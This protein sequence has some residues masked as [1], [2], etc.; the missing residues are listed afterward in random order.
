MFHRLFGLQ[1]KPQRKRTQVCRRRLMVE[2]LEDRRLLATDL[3]DLEAFTGTKPDKE[4]AEIAPSS[5]TRCNDHGCN[6]GSATVVDRPSSTPGKINFSA[7]KT[8]SHFSPQRM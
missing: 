8:I 3:V 6:A 5:V 4:P 1:S 7:M 2:S